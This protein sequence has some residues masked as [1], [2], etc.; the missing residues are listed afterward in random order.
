MEKCLIGFKDYDKHSGKEHPSNCMW[1]YG[2]EMEWKI[3]KGML[4]QEIKKISPSSSIPEM[5]IDHFPFWTDGPAPEY[6]LYCDRA[7]RPGCG[8]C[9]YNPEGAAPVVELFGKDITKEVEIEA[10]RLIEDIRRVLY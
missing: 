10:R 6:L 3:V 1:A 8:N 7:K 9:E 4:I 2:T 5:S